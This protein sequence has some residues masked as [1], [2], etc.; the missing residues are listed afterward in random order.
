M[1]TLDQIADA[2]SDLPMANRRVIKSV[3]VNPAQLNEEILEAAAD[4]EE[5]IF[6]A[7]DWGTM[8]WTDASGEIGLF[9]TAEDWDED[10]FRD[11]LLHET[12]HI[13]TLREWGEDGESGRH[14]RKWRAG[15]KRT[16]FFVSQ[17]AKTEASEDAAEL[18][19]AWCNTVGGPLDQEMRRLFPNIALL[20]TIA[21]INQLLPPRVLAN[22]AAQDYPEGAPLSEDG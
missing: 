17:Y 4:S 19:V 7:I 9:P 20:Q 12:W 21:P 3:Y 22:L 13:L 15:Q 11:I 16:G 2:I 5:A 1:P 6:G 8:M 10:Y 18:G 14:W